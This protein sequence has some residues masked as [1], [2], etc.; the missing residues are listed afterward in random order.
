MKIPGII[1]LFYYFFPMAPA[2]VDCNM[3]IK[4]DFIT[5]VQYGT[6]FADQ[7]VLAFR[8]PDSFSAGQLH[9]LYEQWVF[10]L[11]NNSSK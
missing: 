4:D 6:Q 3:H 8:V 7:S 9:Q 5:A 10:L 11:R 1:P 2:M